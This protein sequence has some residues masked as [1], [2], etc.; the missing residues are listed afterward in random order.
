[1]VAA[2]DSWGPHLSDS[3]GL[4]HVVARGLLQLQVSHLHP[5]PRE[6]VGYHA[7]S[8]LLFYQKSNL[9]QDNGSKSLLVF[10]C[11]TSGPPL[12]SKQAGQVRTDVVVTGVARDQPCLTT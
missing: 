8:L 1:M 2:I 12:A 3:L 5:T 6:W 10:C 9:F 7:Q 11:P 4:S